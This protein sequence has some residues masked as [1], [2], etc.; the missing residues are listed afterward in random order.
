MKTGAEAIRA[1]ATQLPVFRRQKLNEGWYQVRIAGRDAG[2]NELSARL[3]EPLANGAVIHIVPRLA[4]AK[5][6][7]VFQ[8][9][10]GGRLIAVAWW[11]PC[12]LGAAAVS[13]MYAAGASMIPAEWRRCWHRKRDAHGSQY[14]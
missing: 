11:N 13:G 12:G 7:G 2:E 9:V 8:V 3:N 6:G 5:S 10:L 4:G 1:L 14:R